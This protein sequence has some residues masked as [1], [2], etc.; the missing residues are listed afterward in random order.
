MSEQEQ[1]AQ[2]WAAPEVVDT[3]EQEAP[4]AVENT[5]GQTQEDQTAEENADPDGEAE[6]EEKSES[7]KRRER[8]KAH[9]QR[10][11]EEHQKLKEENE[12]LRQQ[13]ELDSGFGDPPKESDYDD[14]G[15]YQADLAAHKAM[16][17]LA[18]RDSQRSKAEM[19]RRE[20]AE[21]ALQQQIMQERME[22]LNEQKLSARERYAD[23]DQV[24]E[25][26]YIPQHVADMVIESDQAADVAYHLG[27]NPV[28]ARQIAQMPPLAAARELGRIEA[29]MSAPKPRTQSKAP[30]PIT[31]VRPAASAA[32]DPDKM[33]SDEYRA[34][35]EAGGT[36]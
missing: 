11:R 4:E 6:A 10:L 17:A 14:Y 12:R 5:E 19:D 30:E 2:E 24:F 33:S 20:E 36:F 3:S 18:A 29:Q 34:W 21:R 32:K 15:Q 13:A 23:F 25:S 9:E 31:P 35:R 7:Q 1:A 22:S 27:K 8:K 16:Q 28:V 26:A